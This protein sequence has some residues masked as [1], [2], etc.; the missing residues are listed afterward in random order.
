LAAFSLFVGVLIC[1]LA[2]VAAVTNLIV[3]AAR[4]ANGELAGE[5]LAVFVLALAVA[6][7]VHRRVVRRLPR[8]S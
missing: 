6:Y 8:R 3:F 1:G 7:Y 5:P 2:I 4:W